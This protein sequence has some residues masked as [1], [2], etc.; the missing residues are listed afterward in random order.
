[1][2]KTKVVG[3]SDVQCP[4]DLDGPEA[5]EARLEDVLRHRC[6][7]E[8]EKRHWKWNESV[9]CLTCDWY[10][11]P[12]RRDG[13]NVHGGRGGRFS[14]RFLYIFRKQMASLLYVFLCVAVD[15]PIAVAS[16]WCSSFEELM[17][18]LAVHDDDLLNERTV[19]S[20]LR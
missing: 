2:E 13:P 1:M 9:A 3:C 18:A 19:V 11:A 14:Q 7:H 20:T 5:A 8:A 4:W 17:S 15:V 16:V 12:R 6:W 10:A